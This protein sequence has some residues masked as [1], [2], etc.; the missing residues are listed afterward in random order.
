M[1]GSVASRA[2]HLVCTCDASLR[3]FRLQD[4]QLQR[5]M[6]VNQSGEDADKRLKFTKDGRLATSR[7]AAI[8]SKMWDGCK[9]H[10]CAP[11]SL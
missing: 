6:K 8:I 11:Q 3:A 9:A 10:P 5:L 4:F 2:D 7:G 1:Q